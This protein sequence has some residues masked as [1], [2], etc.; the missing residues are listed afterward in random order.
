MTIETRKIWLTKLCNY[1]KRQSLHPTE[2]LVADVFDLS[3]HELFDI[4]RNTIISRLNCT[5]NELHRAVLAN[6]QVKDMPIP[7]IN[8]WGKMVIV[9]DV[10]FFNEYAALKELGAIVVQVR[11]TTKQPVSLNGPCHA[12][13]MVDHRMIPDEIVQNNATLGDLEQ[14]VRNVL[15]PKLSR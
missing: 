13:N 7:Q 15:I 2:E 1:I 10:R 9:T 14:Y 5:F 8:K 12:S 4:S 3:D 11:R 6:M